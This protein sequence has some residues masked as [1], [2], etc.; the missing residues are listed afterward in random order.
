M[1]HRDVSVNNIMYEMRNGGYHFILIDFDMAVILPTAAEGSLAASSSHRTGTLPFMACELIFDAAESLEPGWK[2]IQHLLRHD[3]ESLFWV[4]LWC[5]LTLLLKG[6]STKRRAKLVK[7][8]KRLEEGDLIYIAGYKYNISTRPLHQSKIVLPPAA[9]PLHN[10]FM[11][12]GDLLLKVA[13]GLRGF[14]FR[15][16]RIPAYDEDS[17][18]EDDDDAEDEGD[19]EDVEGDN[20]NC[21]VDAA[22]NEGLPTYPDFDSETAGGVITRDNLKSALMQAFPTAEG[23]EEPAESDESDTEANDTAADLT[24]LSKHRTVP[25]KKKDIPATRS[26]RTRR[27][28]TARLVSSQPLENDIRSRLRPRRPRI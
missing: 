13:S 24:H 8:V 3:Y 15:S 27:L 4:S 6:V 2:P 23:P 1:L 9:R 11:A 16:G 22:E 5:V 26:T 20:D 17:E 10:W 14:E 21:D 28:D 19:T 18:D 12:W 7:T 25:E